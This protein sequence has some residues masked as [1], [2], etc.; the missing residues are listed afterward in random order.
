MIRF[1]NWFRWRIRYRVRY[2]LAQK[3]NLF[4]V[5]WSLHLVR[6]EAPWE[7]V[8]QCPPDGGQLTPCCGQSPFDLPRRDRMT[9]AA[10]RVTCSGF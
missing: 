2:W 9:E 6:N 4:M 1:S 7:I 5:L 10:E 8:H 3:P